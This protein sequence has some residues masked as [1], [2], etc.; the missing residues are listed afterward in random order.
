MA[1]FRWLRGFWPRAGQDIAPLDVFVASDRDVLWDDM[2]AE[3]ERMA[4]RLEPAAPWP[5]DNPLW[6]EYIKTV[7]C[8]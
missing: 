7:G 2:L 4:A 5:D 1:L 8:S 6:D 3:G